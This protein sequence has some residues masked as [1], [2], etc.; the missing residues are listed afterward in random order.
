MRS[1]W[2]VSGSGSG[3]YATRDAGLLQA[4]AQRSDQTINVG[5]FKDEGQAHL[6]GVAA[7]THIESLLPHSHGN[8]FIFRFA[9]GSDFPRGQTALHRTGTAVYVGARLP[10]HVL[11]A[12]GDAGSGA[13]RAQVGSVAAKIGCHALMRRERIP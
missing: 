2:R 4:L 10:S 8:F 7:V 9:I 5:F 6:E 12:A 11:D 13:S 1:I 3:D